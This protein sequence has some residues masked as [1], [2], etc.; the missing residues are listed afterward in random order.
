VSHLPSE[1]IEDWLDAAGVEWTFLTSV[2]LDTIDFEKSLRNQARFVDLDDHVVDRYAEAIKNGD[3]FPASVIIHKGTGKSYINVDGN[4]RFAGYRKAGRKAMPAYII[5]KARAQT[6]ALLT[7]EANATHGM[8]TS[9]DER[10]QQAI[11]LVDTGKSQPDAA[12]SVPVPIA[13]VTQDHT[14]LQASCRGKAEGIVDIQRSTPRIRRA[15]CRCSAARP[16]QLPIASTPLK[17]RLSSLGIPADHVCVDG[18]VLGEGLLSAGRSPTFTRSERLAEDATSGP[19]AAHMTSYGARPT[20]AAPAL[21]ELP[22]DEQWGLSQEVADGFLLGYTGNTLAAYRRD[23][24]D[25]ASYCVDVGIAPL[26][27]SRRHIEMYARAMAGSRGLSAS[28]VS[29]RLTTLAGFFRYALEDD[30]VTRSPMT[31]VRRPAVDVE[32]PKQGLDRGE[33]AALLVA[34]AS[35][36]A[37]AELLVTALVYTG[38]RISE[39]V[40]ASVADLAIERG[41]RVV[42][43]TR[44]GGKHQSLPLPGPVAQALDAYLAGRIEGPLLLSR[45]GRRLDRS[46]A[47]RL[48]KQVGRD[49]LPHRRDLSPH[50][51]RHTMITLALDAGV[52]LRDVQDGA[53]HA[54][55]ATTRRYDDSRGAHDRNPAY[56]LARYLSRTS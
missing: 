44:K 23:L 50:T 38:L 6:I 48:L 1:E 51:L 39:L 12:K 31:G 56:E 49:A 47:A 37:R 36:S 10:V 4:H 20:S 22:V 32:S 24:R 25:F 15:N 55:P 17:P 21:T 5:T 40:G 41:H 54:S 7:Y 11:Y 26:A 53:G 2:P 34:A 14:M 18:M 43:V 3:K 27:A 46:S 52:P 33:A 30:A 16:L 35:H 29:R 9:E 13:A 28:T 42:R 19:G 8:P 45:T